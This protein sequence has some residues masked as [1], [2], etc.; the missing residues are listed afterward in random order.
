M[1][2]TK[3]VKIIK[4]TKELLNQG[5]LVFYWGAEAPAGAN[6]V[7]DSLNHSASNFPRIFHTH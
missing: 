6:A 3:L 2:K 1:N 5:K 7:S 4:N